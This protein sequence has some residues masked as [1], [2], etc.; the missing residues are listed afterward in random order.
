MLC[1]NCTK[2][3]ASSNFAS[4]LCVYRALGITPACNSILHQCYHHRHLS[5]HGE[6]GLDSQ[7]FTPLLGKIAPLPNNSNWTC[8]LRHVSLC[9]CF[10]KLTIWLVVLCKIFCGILLPPALG[11]LISPVC[12]CVCDPMVYAHRFCQWAPRYGKS[13][14]SSA[15]NK[16]S[17]TFQ[18]G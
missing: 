4:S 7:N 18:T 17:A 10:C 1:R 8:Q 13:S 11:N 2:H 6:A 9:F 16:S 14:K 15:E 12:V 5:F 3:L